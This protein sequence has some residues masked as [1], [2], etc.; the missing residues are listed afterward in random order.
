VPLPTTC[1]ITPTSELRQ[2]QEGDQRLILDQPLC[3]TADT[4]TSS[5]TGKQ[6]L[7]REQPKKRGRT[8]VPVSRQRRLGAVGRHNSIQNRC[9]YCR[10]GGT[11]A[12]MLGRQ[13]DCIG[14][15]LANTEKIVAE[16]M[17]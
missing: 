3:Y 16:R 12:E 2:Q 5:N 1:R 4:P 13:R 15:A 8:E 7:V 9:Q 11:R 14:I 10:R 17:T 6:R